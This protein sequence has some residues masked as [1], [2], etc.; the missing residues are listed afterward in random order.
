MEFTTPGSTTITLP[1][2]AKTM[3]LIACGGG[4]ESRSSLSDY[5]SGGGGGGGAAISNVTY[6][7]EGLDKI[8]I[9]MG[10]GG[11]DN[12]YSNIVSNAI[13]IDN[14]NTIILDGYNC[15]IFEVTEDKDIVWD[16][17]LPES[18]LRK[19]KIIYRIGLITEEEYNNLFN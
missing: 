11:S 4:F 12:F 13:C 9:T 1:P 6:N 2:G 10:S 17:I 15:R 14:G 8:T 7:I 3:K 16:F 19:D 5:Y 18:E